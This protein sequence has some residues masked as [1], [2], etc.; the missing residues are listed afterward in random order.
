[1]DFEAIEKE[2]KREFEEEWG[3]TSVET[4]LETN[5]YPRAREEFSCFEIREDQAILSVSPTELGIP[6]MLA[7][8]EKRS[9][10]F[11][12]SARS[13]SKF[14]VKV[15]LWVSSNQSKFIVLNKEITNNYHF[16]ATP[17]SWLQ[18]IKI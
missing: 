13:D 1:M 12:V 14:Q 11:Q 7:P 10:N 15:N 3:N 18:T 8:M 17:R 2:V 5:E 16:V 6:E 4:L 9:L